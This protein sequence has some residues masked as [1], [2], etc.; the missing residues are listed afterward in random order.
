MANFLESQDNFHNNWK[1][2]NK[3]FKDN[4]N[5]DISNYIQNLNFNKINNNLNLKSDDTISYF[6]EQIEKKNHNFFS[7]LNKIDSDKDIS[8]LKSII[9]D[10][11]NNPVLN[12]KLKDTFNIYLNSKLNKQEIKNKI[13]EFNNLV[14]SSSYEVQS[15]IM[16]MVQ[17]AVSSYVNFTFSNNKL[18]G[19]TI[20]LESLSKNN[21]F[22]E[23]A[24]QQKIGNISLKNVSNVLIN[25]G[26]TNIHLSNEIVKGLSDKNPVVKVNAFN[27]AV[28]KEVIN[29]EKD[30]QDLANSL[31]SALCKDYGTQASRQEIQAGKS[32]VI[33]EKSPTA[34]ISGFS[35]YNVNSSF[36]YSPLNGAGF[37]GT[38][39][40]SV[41]KY[42]LN[43][44]KNV[45][46]GFDINTGLTIGVASLKGNASY[47][48]GDYSEK[49]IEFDKIV[50]VT[51][52]TVGFEYKKGNTTI[53]AGIMG[54]PALNTKV[55]NNKIRFTPTIQSEVYV[56]V[57]IKFL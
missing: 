51:N 42:D 38:F 37:K 44:K 57:N 45:K 3:Q 13:N 28:G 8:D 19:A 6:Q 50:P 53:N 47:Y 32:T 18:K 20:N 31:V 55:E 43:L 52:A 49:L 33:L 21:Q 46:S 22:N 27:S 30:S 34:T 1:T 5:Q 40:G 10:M 4:I 29:I 14:T 41:V 35:I 16:N 17:T 56:K 36:N 7:K 48:V 54:F 2:V 23:F 24:E 15:K 26:I 12:I 25:S 11:S 9:K 39:S